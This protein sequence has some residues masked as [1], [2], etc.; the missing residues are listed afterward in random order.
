MFNLNSFDLTGKCA[1]V[2]G[3][4]GGIGKACCEALLIFGAKVFIVDLNE[5]LSQTVSGFTNK[6]YE[7]SGTRSDVTNM[8]NIKISY[9]TAKSF[10]EKTP[11]ILINAAGIQHRESSE[12]FQESDWNRIIDVNLKAVFLYSQIVAQDMLAIGSGKIINIASLMSN[13][14]GRKIP[15]YAASKGGV[16]QLTKAM[17]NDLAPFGIQINAIAPGYIE[18]ALNS[19]ILM[20][21]ERS[22]EIVGRTPIGRWGTPDDLK[23]CVV[24]LSSA[25]SNFISGTI[26]TVDGGYSAR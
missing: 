25:A 9:K 12:S 1:I 2:I 17:S 24:F 6:G 19:E 18:T 13:F 15:A 11:D 14:G 20:D 26:F 3:G 8:D 10:F 5:E 23:G 4:A 7:C 22:K 21:L 16:A